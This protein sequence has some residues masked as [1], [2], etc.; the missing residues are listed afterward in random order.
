[1]QEGRALLTQSPLKGPTS[2]RCHIGGYISTWALEETDIQTIAPFKEKSEKLCLCGSCPIEVFGESHI[3]SFTHRI[4]SSNSSLFPKPKV[5]LDPL[6]LE[7]S[8]LQLQPLFL[9][10]SRDS[11][12]FG[13]KRAP[14]KFLYL[15]NYK[16][17]RNLLISQRLIFPIGIIG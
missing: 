5:H 8:K 1:M 11:S 3:S 15:T 7:T 13:I 4:L 14:D 6:C 16:T 17:L 10:G 9:W 12:R 2:Q